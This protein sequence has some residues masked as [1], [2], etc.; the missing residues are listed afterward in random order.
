[1]TPFRVFVF[2]A[3]LRPTLHACFVQVS[4]EVAVV[5][6]VSLCGGEMGGPGGRGRVCTVCNRARVRGAQHSHLEPWVRGSRGSGTRAGSHCSEGWANLVFSLSEVR[7]PGPKRGAAGPRAGSQ[8][9]HPP[10]PGWGLGHTCVS[11]VT[12]P[13]L[14]ADRRPLPFLRRDG[15]WSTLSRVHGNL[16]QKPECHP[17]CLWCLINPHAF[18]ADLAAHLDTRFKK[19]LSCFSA[20]N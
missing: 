12:L 10:E 13:S 8:D 4:G 9:R 3:E 7:R 19:P 11:L 1:M 18:R 16:V 2:F 5:R 15:L 14:P 17:A 6:K 20:H